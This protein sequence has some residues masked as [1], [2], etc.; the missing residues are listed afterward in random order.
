[1]RFYAHTVSIVASYAV[2]SKTYLGESYIDKPTLATA[3][4]VAVAAPN[5]TSGI[6]AALGAQLKAFLPLI[7]K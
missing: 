7:I 6:N 4:M 1:M 2:T 5:T 3:N